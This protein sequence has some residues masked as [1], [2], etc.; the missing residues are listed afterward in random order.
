GRRD[1][2]LAVRYEQMASL[3]RL[4]HEMKNALP[5]RDIEIKIRFHPSAMRMSRHRVPNAALLEDGE[6]HDELTATDA[7]RV[8]VFIDRSVIGRFRR[9]RAYGQGFFLRQELN[10]MRSMRGCGQKEEASGFPR[11][12]AFKDNGFNTLT[13]VKAI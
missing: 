3:L 13:N 12:L 5:F 2:A 1:D 8:N 6:P 4:T 9:T 11:S 7:V 10:G